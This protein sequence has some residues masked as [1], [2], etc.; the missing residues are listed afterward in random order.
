MFVRKLTVFLSVCLLVSCSDRVKETSQ[1]EFSGIYPHLAFYNSQ[2]ECGTGAVVPW[3]GDL[4]AVTYSPHEPFGSDDKLYQISPSLEETVRPESVGGTHADRMIHDE[5]G[6]LF[7]GPYAID[8][9][10][11]VRV[12]P[13]DKYPGRHTGV[14]RHLDDPANRVLLAT[15]EAGFYDVN[16]HSL[17]AVELYTDGNKKRKDGFT[18]DLCTMFPGYHGKGF[19]SGQGVAVYS[20]NGEEGALAKEQFD[21]PSGALVE[22]DGKDWTLIRRNQFTDITGPGGIHG[23]PSPATDPIWSLGWDYRSVI[24]AVREPRKGW[25]FYRLPK[26]SF[27]YD[28][29]HGWNTEWPRIRNVAPEGADPEYLMTMHGMFWHFPGSFSTGNSSGIRPRGAYLKVIADFTEWNGRLVFGCDDSAQSEFLNKRRQKGGIGGPGQ[30]NSNLWFTSYDQ[31][32]NLGPVT[33]GG[34]VWLKDEVQANVPSDP[35]LFNGWDN[36]CAWVA[37]RS[38]KESRI[39]F[40]V[41]RKGD[42]QWV[43]LKTIFVGSGESLFVP[44]DSGDAGVWVRALSSSDILADLTFVYAPKETR[45]TTPDPIFKG[46]AKVDETND[47]QGLLYG[48]PDQRRALGILASTAEGERYYELDGG[49]N[50][51]EKDDSLMERHIREKLRIP[52]G[53]VECQEGS[54]LIVD[55][56]GRRWRLPLGREEYAEKTMAGALRICREVVT[57]RDLLSLGGTFYELPAENADGYAKVR[58]IASH[59]FG[60]HDYASYRGMLV[61]TGIDHSAARKNPHVVF[62]PDRKAAVWAGTIDDLW[63]LG[64]PTGH[65]GP[66]AG[67]NVK[68]GECSDPFLIGFYDKREMSLSHDC[69]QEVIFSVEVDPTGDGQWF[70]Y[71]NFAVAPGQN[72]KHDFP[73][74]FQA[75]WIRVKADHDATATVLFDYR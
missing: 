49:M 16:V 60:I 28:G 41:D 31:P 48:L 13:L 61:M 25:S 27:A 42:G 63:K 68:A 56:K 55:D 6:Q 59:D 73:A 50:L 34:S 5:S 44:F 2:G 19:Y 69:P 1:K 33:A 47:S 58:P 66:W 7:I 52:T 8:S 14:A 45:G 24:L 23:S 36:R 32:D 37:N 21:I 64:K 20:N 65:G 29:A 9:E 62:S 71:A 18:G 12:L 11:N 51:L 43:D 10:K 4:W 53:V 54:I 57:E 22:W 26:A 74:S 39:T 67:T 72:L 17:D 15:M 46:L 40:Q 75:R 38:D 70:H 3:Q 35:F 30:S